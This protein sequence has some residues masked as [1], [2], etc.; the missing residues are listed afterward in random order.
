[1]RLI[2]LNA[3]VGLVIALTYSA[4]AQQ[5]NTRVCIGRGNCPAAVQ[6]MRDCGSS[7]EQIAE[8]ICTVRSGGGQTRVLEHNFVLEGTKG[9]GKCGF[10]RYTVSCYR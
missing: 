3:S 8:E 2:A 6:A 1:M 10:S 9:G 5:Q 4:A 7:I